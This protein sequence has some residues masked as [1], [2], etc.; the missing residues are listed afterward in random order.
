MAEE[1]LGWKRTFA[2]AL[3]AFAGVVV[4]A[5]LIHLARRG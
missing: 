1:R 5:W 3:G 4:T 2:L